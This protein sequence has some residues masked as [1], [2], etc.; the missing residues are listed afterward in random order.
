MNPLTIDT[1]ETLSDKSVA[2]LNELQAAI[3]FTPNIFTVV[4]QS[5]TVLEAFVNLNQSF[6]AGTLT[7]EEQQLIL[8]IAST[9]NDSGYCVAGHTS[10]AESLSISADLVY[11]ARARQPMADERLNALNTV[12]RSLIKNKGHV[13]SKDLS[14]FYRVGY[15]QAQF[16]E[17]LLGI[18][19]KTISNFAS[20]ALNIP[21]DNQF[22]PFSWS[23][24]HSVKKSAA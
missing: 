9:E 14:E 23:C 6:A 13:S 10:F 3:G 24:I 21:L 8:L 15:T 2:I 11:D 1:T 17:V 18:S 19:I 20:L 12:V 4:A 5:P 7:S 22:K 16:L